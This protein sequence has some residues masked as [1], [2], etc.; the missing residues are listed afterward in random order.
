MKRSEQLKLEHLHELIHE[1]NYKVN[2]IM[3]TLQDVQ[4]AVSQQSTVE[5]SVITLLN[6]IVQQLK[7]AQASNDPAALDKVVADIQAN[8][9]RLTDAV[10]QNTPAQNQA[11]NTQ[12]A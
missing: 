11:S 8:T 9:Q 5:D 3:A 1:I 6:N 4:N 2:Y 12:S 10:T 7:D